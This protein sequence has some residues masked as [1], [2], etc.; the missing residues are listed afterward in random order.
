MTLVDSFSDA[1]RQTPNPLVWLL[2]MLLFVPVW[3][4]FS[5]LLDRLRGCIYDLLWIQRNKWQRAVIALVVVV[6]L[7]HYRAAFA[8]HLE[9]YL[10]K[11][12][13]D[14]MK[15]HFGPVLDVDPALP[16]RR[17]LIIGEVGDGKSTMINALRDPA[18]S[19][20]A[21]SGRAAGG[22][23]KA[24]TSYV[25]LPINGQRVELLDTPGVGDMDITATALISLLE[26]RLG[27]HNQGPKLDGVLATSQVADGR[28][29][30]GAQVVQAI[31]DKGFLGGDKWSNIILVGTKNDRVE[32]EGQRTFFRTEIMSAFYAQAPGQ[33]GA[34]AL[35]S[36]GDYSELRRA[37]T[38]LPG[39]G[40]VYVPPDAA[41]MH[42]LLA[43]KM[44]FREQV[45]DFSRRLE[46]AR[47]QIR[48]EYKEQLDRQKKEGMD[49]VWRDY[50]GT[51]RQPRGAIATLT[52]RAISTL[53]AKRSRL[54]RGQPPTSRRICGR[55]LSSS[56]RSRSCY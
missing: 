20:P 44:G 41:L 31:V 35:V 11:A 49:A 39:L 48:A 46:E 21:K 19:S 18:R 54:S 45:E 17:L 10:S 29:R 47:E 27:A 51:R 33:S 3:R 36:Q 32:D 53:T 5:W 23:T 1:L 22:V 55:S 7:H 25:G 52:A 9:K 2:F 56:L 26:E 16:I 12:L 28:M 43:E 14:L 6:L 4:Q 40:I 30:L 42:A 50:G 13:P 38:M 37:I 24:I 8:Q 34:V 15:V